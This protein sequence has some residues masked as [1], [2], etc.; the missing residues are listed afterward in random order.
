MIP[1][2]FAPVTDYNSMRLRIALFTFLATATSLITASLSIPELGQRLH[3]PPFNDIDSLLKHYPLL[4]PAALLTLF[5]YMIKF[6][7]RL[8]D[9]LRIR[10]HFDRKHVIR[11]LALAAGVDAT[12]LPKSDDFRHKAMKACFYRYASSKKPQID[13]H[14]IEEALGNWAWF[15]VILES[16]AVFGISS[17]C[18]FPFATKSY[19]FYALLIALIVAAILLPFFWKEAIKYAGAQVREIMDDETRANHV[20]AFFHAL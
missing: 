6:H 9:V 16:L 10:R 19:S 15:W 11:P 17:A 5:L 14:N 3:L 20:R 7:D 4:I 1:N 13:T 2:P 18:V 12:K 8:S